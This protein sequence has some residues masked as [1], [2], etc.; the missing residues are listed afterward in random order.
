MPPGR[1]TVAYGSLTATTELFRADGLTLTSSSDTV[2]ADVANQVTGPENLGG[3]LID[4]SAVSGG[5]LIVSVSA[6]SGT[7]PTLNFW[8][9][10]Q[11]AYG[12]WAQVPAQASG[13][14]TSNLTTTGVSAA[15]LASVTLAAYTARLAWVVGGTTPSFTVSVNVYGR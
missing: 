8:L 12:N 1:A 11:D 4:V 14:F 2:T 10:V 13:I 5:L 15:A 3:G 7:T 6:K 9:D